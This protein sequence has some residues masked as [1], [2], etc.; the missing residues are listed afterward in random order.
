MFLNLDGQDIPSHS[1]VA[2]DAIGPTVETALLCETDNVDC[3]T[4]NVTGGWYYPNGSAVESTPSN[5]HAFYTSV[6]NQLVYLIRGPGNPDEG[7]YSCIVPDRFSALQ[8]LYVGLYM[9]GGQP[10]FHI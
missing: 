2:I 1:Y 5:V 4:E 3:C 10:L 8:T 7:M 6:G 9:T